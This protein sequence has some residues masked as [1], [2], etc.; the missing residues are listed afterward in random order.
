[1]S[2]EWGTIVKSINWTLVLGLINFAI[3]L[4]ILKRLLFKPAMEYLDRRRELIAGRMASAQASEEEAAAL[5]AE[6]SR[7]LTEARERA[8]TIVEGAQ[9]RS[10]EMIDEAKLKARDEADRIVA[11]V[12]T[13]MEQERDEMIRDLKMAYAEIAVLGAERVLDREVRIEDH[14]QLLDRLSAEIDD[15]TLK[16][17]P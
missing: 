7:E 14:R 4:Y 9:T 1:V 16:V 12:R 8:A 17:R 3:L 15:E 2:F 5:A 6:R 10:A 13:R 11:D